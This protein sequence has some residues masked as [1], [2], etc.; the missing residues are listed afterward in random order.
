[1][2][3]ILFLFLISFY[4]CLIRIRKVFV[5]MYQNLCVCTIYHTHALLQSLSGV[6]RHRVFRGLFAC[7]FFNRRELG[8][9]LNALIS[10]FVSI[11]LKLKYFI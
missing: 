10:R 5:R 1:M 6:L 8:A 11:K 2:Q 4:L 9:C 3:C 7:N